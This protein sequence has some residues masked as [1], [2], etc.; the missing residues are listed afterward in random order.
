MEPTIRELK[1]GM[2]SLSITFIVLDI[3]RPNM[4]K[5]GHEVR[6]CKVA[7]RSGSINLS[8]WDEPG[9]CIQEGDICKL[10]K[11][12]VSL[13]KGCL[14]LYTG[15]GGTIQKIGEFCLPFSETPFM[16]EP[17]PEYM[18]QLT[19]K[20]NGTVDQRRA[21]T[22][23]SGGSSGDTLGAA[24]LPTPSAGGDDPSGLGYS[25]RGGGLQETLRYGFMSIPLTSYNNGFS[26]NEG[27]HSA[28]SARPNR[29]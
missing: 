17:N 24:L 27:L 4:T 16:S 6:T 19:A 1:M 3:G 12:Y 22:S 23:Q 14:T 13:W 28:K 18:K 15:K 25:Q 11:G 10:T 20:L 9:T 2:K 21:P 8:L 29:R 7:D 26:I 5:E